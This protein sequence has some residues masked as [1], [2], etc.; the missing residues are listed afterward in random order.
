MLGDL[1]IR[2]GSNEKNSELDLTV[3]RNGDMFLGQMRGGKI[4]GLGYFLAESPHL[5]CAGDWKDGLLSGAGC[6]KG[7]GKEVYYGEFVRGARSGLGKLEDEGSLILGNFLDGEINGFCII[8]DKTKASETLGNFK[9]GLIHG[10]GRFQSKDGEYLYIGPFHNGKFQGAGQETIRGSTFL[11]EFKNGRREGIGAYSLKDCNYFGEWKAGEREGF[12]IEKF[13]NKGIYQGDYNAD[14]KNGTGRYVDFTDSSTYVGHFK[15]GLR[16]G[17]GH[18]QFTPNSFY[19][20]EWRSDRREGQGLLIED[21]GRLYF[22]NWKRNQ[23]DGKGV[24]VSPSLTYRGDFAGDRPHGRGIFKGKDDKEERL[25]IFEYGV[26]VQVKKESDFRFAN[27]QE[28]DSFKPFLRSSM[29]RIGELDRLI[30]RK[31][32]LLE[33][34]KQSYKEEIKFKGENLEQLMKELKNRIENVVFSVENKLL[35]LDRQ[36]SASKYSHILEGYKARFESTLQPNESVVSLRG[37]TLKTSKTEKKAAK[38]YQSSHQSRTTSKA[39]LEADYQEDSNVIFHD[40]KRRRELDDINR[41]LN[42]LFEEVFDD[43]KD[44]VFE[45]KPTLLENKRPTFGLENNRHS[46]RDLLDEA[47]STRSMEEK[48]NDQIVDIEERERL[49]FIEKMAIKK[50]KEEILMLID[51]LSALKA[52][53]TV[54][55]SQPIFESPG[56]TS[57]KQEPDEEVSSPLFEEGFRNQK[58]RLEI[59]Q[60]ETN[61]LINS[62]ENIDQEGSKPYR[63]SEIAQSILL[64]NVSQKKEEWSKFSHKFKIAKIKLAFGNEN[65]KILY[66]EKLNELL[67]SVDN[68]LYRIKVIPEKQP[69]VISVNQFEEGTD[70][71]QMFDMNGR[72]GV[73]IQ[74]SFEVVF[75]DLFDHSYSKFNA[76]QASKSKDSEVRKLGMI[77]SS[78]NYKLFNIDFKSKKSFISFVPPCTIGLVSISNYHQA[79]FFKL[80]EGNSELVCTSINEDDQEAFTLTKESRDES[81]GSELMYSMH[82]YNLE[83]SFRFRYDMSYLCPNGKFQ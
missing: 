17:F 18:I 44:F 3:F 80:Y 25:G 48:Y 20:G 46:A 64:S 82:Y 73:L 29:E 75:I 52:K 26:L 23:R 58:D 76:L 66:Y 55:K 10:F 22:G 43:Q 2:E 83:T 60:E 31:I 81:Q 12:G 13:K 28:L 24:M 71:I 67:M 53:T 30:N 62:V 45:Q 40:T 41:R 69:K 6:Q 63:G 9:D 4:Q 35:K 56:Q 77:D 5:M 1:S 27:Y 47:T 38:D 37:S 11:G 16:H 8:F 39:R 42:H 70:V 61:N 21:D 50:Q 74:P 59:I 49:L 54:G 68:C 15:D 72:Y 19:V 36:I 51:E 57:P 33:D 7:P 34:S 32:K 14:C 78:D 65:S 79:K